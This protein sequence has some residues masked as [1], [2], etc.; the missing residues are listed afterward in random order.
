MYVVVTPVDHVLVE[1][2]VIWRMRHLPGFLRASEVVATVRA[3]DVE[4]A[5]CGCQRRAQVELQVLRR[6]LASCVGE[7]AGEEVRVLRLLRR[8]GDH[9]VWRE[10]S[11]GRLCA[12]PPAVVKGRRPVTSH[13]PLSLTSLSPIRSRI[14]R[15]L[16]TA[17]SR[18]AGRCL[19]MFV[20]PFIDR[21]AHHQF[22]EP[23]PHERARQCTAGARRPAFVRLL[24][25]AP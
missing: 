17:D 20:R 7:M 19:A 22:P 2:H 12:V 3:H 11:A 15:T 4:R 18:F 21:E 14:G 8:V 10:N 13:S 6:V 25:V 23:C 5:P 24:P 9:L 16:V 1:R